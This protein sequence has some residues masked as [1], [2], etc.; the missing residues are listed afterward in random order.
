M[1]QSLQEHLFSL[2]DAEYRTFQCRLMPT[3]EM[4]RVIGIRIPVLRKFSREFCRMCD[5][6]TFLEALPHQYYEENNLHGMLISQMSSFSQ[7][8]DA[9]D[10]FLPYVDNWA[11]CDLISP[12]SFQKRPPEL[13]PKIQEWIG[14]SHAYTARFGIGMLLKFYLDDGFEPEYLAWVCGISSAEYYVNMMVAWYFAT[15]LAQQYEATIPYIQENRLPS[16][17]HNK[18]IQKAVESRRISSEKK[19]YLRNLKQ[20]NII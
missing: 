7:T 16:W 20:T 11:T 14:S 8:I 5:S 18:A 13:I 1:N 6:E 15:A 9:L 4:E 19:D 2:S 3:V 17:T 10:A 12:K